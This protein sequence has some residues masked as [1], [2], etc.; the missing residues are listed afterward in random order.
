MPKLSIIIPTHKRADILKQCLDHLASQTIADAIEVIVIHDGHDD[1]T[2]ALMAK[3]SWQIPI[4]YESIPKSQQGVARNVGVQ[5]AQSST[6]LFIGDDIF[7]S[8]Q[9]C[10]RHMKA[11]EKSSTPIAVIGDIDWDPNVGITKAMT[12]LMDSGWQFGFKKIEQFKNDFIPQSMQHL[13]SY[14]S[15][16][17]VPTEVALRTPFRNDITMYGWEDMEWGMQLRKNGVRLFFEPHA[18]GLHHH[19]IDLPASLKRMEVIGTSAIIIGNLIDE[20]DRVPKGWKRIG[21][22]ILSHL[23]TMAGK[24]RKAF[25]KGIRKA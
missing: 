5:K 1:K 3:H 7:L 23:P 6:C 14:T 13:F 22:E 24:H 16:I 8:P 9:A 25:L 11:H 15:N 18:K 12:W 17:S 20:F 2:D 10:E 21:Y 4:Y 19:K